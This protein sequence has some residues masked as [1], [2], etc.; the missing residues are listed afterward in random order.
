MS[1]LE[2][3]KIALQLETK[4]VLVFKTGHVTDLLIYQVLGRIVAVVSTGWA[5]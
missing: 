2:A 4:Q 5:I 1:K 3:R